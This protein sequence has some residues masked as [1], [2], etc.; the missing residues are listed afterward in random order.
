MK[1]KKATNSALVLTIA[2][3]LAKIIGALYRVPLT[4]I[5]GAQ[6]M[7]M[8]QLIFPIYALLVTLLA[9]GVPI[10]VT[11]MVAEK[12]SLG[13]SVN[14]VL[15]I[16]VKYS[17]LL[18]LI[19]SVGLIF[20]AS[21]IARIQGDESLIIGY[22]AIAPALIFVGIISV[23]KG[24][25]QGNFNMLPTALSYIIEQGVKLGLGL[26]LAYKFSHYGLMYS[27]VGAILGVTLSEVICALL[28][29]V[30]Y[31]FSR[32]NTKKITY[33]EPD[34]PQKQ[35][36]LEERKRISK[37]FRLLAGSI[38]V[39]SL[40]FPLAHFIDSILIVKLLVMHGNAYDYAQS[41]YG[42]MAGTV[43]SLVNMP[44]ILILSLAIVVI[45]S[46]SVGVVERS[47]ENISSK[48]RLTLKI[49]C[50]IGLPIAVL[51]QI[52]AQSIVEML[53][54]SFVATEV[55][56]ATR[57]LRV[58]VVSIIFLALMQIFVSLLQAMDKP[59]WATANLTISITL[60]IVLEVLLVVPYGIDG[61]AVA[62]VIQSVICTVLNVIAY[63]MLIGKIGRLKQGL[64]G[65]VFST[66][67]VGIVA[68]VIFYYFIP[69]I[70]G[71]IVA[72]IVAL[73]LYLS[74][75]LLLGVFT[76]EELITFPLSKVWLAIDSKLRKKEKI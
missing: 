44:V 4:N 28:M 11:K 23:F 41:V 33:L 8:Y 2:L 19:A 63:N 75:I 30:I 18:S 53:Y 37:K 68:F 20:F 70:W 17:V 58:S 74:M 67:V 40:M 31:V 46:I 45:P 66:I 32:K 34:F 47:I 54:P 24:Y 71:I 56:I 7:G 13:E 39:G 52:F 57:L 48:C 35:F 59:K 61:M 60:G 38:T 76:R 3:F 10:A 50:A 15:R 21:I 12:R 42:I 36:S 43:S 29:L 72:S 65:L 9:S 49:A 69:N 27:V 62:L 6:G 5:L 14:D 22:Y 64:V 25:F 51:M 1:I 55:L 26:A 73:A 16:G